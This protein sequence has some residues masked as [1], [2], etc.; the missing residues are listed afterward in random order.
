VV[1]E[2]D[3]IKNDP[4]TPHEPS[5]KRPR[6]GKHWW[7]DSAQTFIEGVPNPEDWPRRRQELALEDDNGNSHIIKEIICGL[8]E[9][10]QDLDETAQTAIEMTEN[11]KMTE[12]ERLL[13]TGRSCAKMLNKSRRRNSHQTRIILYQEMVLA[14]YFLYLR[15]YKKIPV[16]EVDEA[17]REAFPES[18]NPTHLYHLRR[19]GQWIVDFTKTL[20]ENDFGDLAGEVPLISYVT[21]I[22]YLRS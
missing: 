9:V 6:V 7:D 8:V 3:F 16:L 1:T 2:K 4:P 18:S 17:M 10:R 11:E 22:L 14:A 20:Y 5:P 13:N 15:H 21:V 19:A 12:N